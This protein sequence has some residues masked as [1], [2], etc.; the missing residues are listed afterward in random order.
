MSY[1]L[2]TIALVPVGIV[3]E[4]HLRILADV[5]PEI[6][7]GTSCRKMELAIDARQFQSSS[8][9]Q[10]NSTGILSALRRNGPSIDGGRILGVIDLDLY[11]PGMNFVFGEAELP[12]RV[13]LV[14]AYRLKGTTRHGGEELLP[15]RL[16]KEAVHELGHTLGL[17]H[18]GRSSCVMHFS[19]SLDDTDGKTEHYCTACSTKLGRAT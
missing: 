4:L 19:N 11:V 6:L 17:A 14:S 2:H 3:E 16:I 1:D 10:Y 18:C 9:R 7:P 5:L 12:G 8:S 13:A 15:S